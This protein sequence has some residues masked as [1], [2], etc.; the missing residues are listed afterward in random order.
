MEFSLLPVSKLKGVT[1]LDYEMG[2][3]NL[4]VAPRVHSHRRL[5]TKGL[6]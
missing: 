1:K 5:S 2:I 6:G 3:M 4:Q